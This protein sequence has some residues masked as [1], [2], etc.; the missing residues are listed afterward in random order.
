MFA[1][2][3]NYQHVHL[4]KI[5]IGDKTETRITRGDYSVLDYQHSNNG[6]KV[7]YHRSINPLFGDSD[8]SEVWVMKADGSAATQLTRNHVPEASAR[9]SPDNK[10][11]LFLAKANEQFEYYYNAN[12]FLVPATGGDAKRL[13]PDLPYEIFAADWSRDGRSIFFTANMGVHVELFQ[14]DVA[15]ETLKQ[16]TSGNHAIRSW[17]YSKASGRHVMSIDLP[18]NPGDVMDDRK[19]LDCQG[20]PCDSKADHPNIRPAGRTLFDCRNNNGLHGAVLTTSK[21]KDCSSTRLIIKKESVIHW[22]CRR[23]VVRRVRIGSDSVRGATT[24]RF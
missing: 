21:S 19:S 16:L 23:T 8:Q 15:T 17:H 2:D 9:F 6:M 12:L 20:P 7:T 1:F 22:S 11:V 4:W 18:D 24:F 3:E 13:L 10:H 14:L 5:A